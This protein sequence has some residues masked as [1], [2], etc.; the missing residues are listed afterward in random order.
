MYHGSVPGGPLDEREVIYRHMVG[1][2]PFEGGARAAGEA[3]PDGD[4]EADDGPTA[5][6]CLGCG[7]VT[8]ADGLPDSCPECHRM[9]GDRGDGALFQPL[10]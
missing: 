1:E 7:A 6:A 2:E 9:P 5:F 3:E 10:D 4:D 8:T